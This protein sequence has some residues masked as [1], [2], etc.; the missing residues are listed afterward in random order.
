MAYSI[1]SRY[2][3][4]LSL[5]EEL[6]RGAKLHVL[7]LARAEILLM[8]TDMVSG[9]GISNKLFLFHHSSRVEFEEH[10]IR[11]TKRTLII[12]SSSSIVRDLWSM[13]LSLNVEPQS[14]NITRTSTLSSSS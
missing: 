1:E 9:C 14:D 5:P 2:K 3:P 4:L 12:T 6:S 10:A 13:N 7:F 11:H 8:Q